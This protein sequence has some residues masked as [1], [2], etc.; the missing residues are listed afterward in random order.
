[1]QKF[2]TILSLLS[3]LLLG[4]ST[5]FA[6]TASIENVK[7]V[8]L[9][10]GGA[11]INEGIIQG[12]YY[13]YKM[14]RVD[15]KTRA[16]GLEIL[17]QNLEKVGSKKFKGSK[18]LQLT[19]GAYN[20]SSI[21]LKFY[22]FKKKKLDFKRYD[23]N[24]KLIST[25]SLDVKRRYATAQIKGNDDEIEGQT[26]LSIPNKGFAHILMKKNKRVGY[27]VN[28]FP[29]EGKGW[30]FGSPKEIKE[31]H[32]A[33][34]LVADENIL[35]LNVI[36]KKKALSKKMIYSIIGLDINTGKKLFEKELDN[37]K[38]TLQVMNAFIDPD[39]KDITLFG[40]YYKK[41][42]N[43]TKAKSIGL[44]SY[45]MDRDGK[46][47]SKKFISW[48][49]DIG[50]HL[51]VNARGNMKG[52]GYIFFHKI[53][54]TADGKILAVGEMYNKELS[55]LG[56][57]GV[58]ESLAKIVV[59]NLYIFEFNADFTLNDVKVYEKTKKNIQLPE[60]S[61]LTGP[62]RLALLVNAYGDF[63][64]E[65]TQRNKDNSVISFG[66]INREKLKKLKHR[67]VFGSVTYVDG[68][69]STDKIDLGKRAYRLRV[70]PAKPG[71]VMVAEYLRKEKKIEMRLE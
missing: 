42:A 29:E 17:D 15:R 3:I 49:K 18:Y 16:Y 46:K 8:R 51:P 58:A 26:L 10:N 7:K 28:Y 44:F 35:V 25:K 52:K 30:K 14:G 11:I 36:K 9:R 60:G 47:K 68:E 71:Y 39:T 70:F 40:L 63:D 27:Q 22:D 53:I 32:F 31:A 38:N 1:M 67:Y 21:M 6:Q 50:K 64:Y 20:G 23:K 2:L 48:A 54:K 59:K 62:Q 61:E 24:A 66:Y 4:T 57:L 41:K 43:M 45:T 69:Y 37:S 12:Y 19:E 65:F 56:V 13:F 33:D 5:L 34:F 55:A